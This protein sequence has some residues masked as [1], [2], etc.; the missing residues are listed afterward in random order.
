MN[1]RD[2]LKTMALLGMGL[3]AAAASASQ[4]APAIALPPP[5]TEGGVPL[6]QAIARRRSVREFSPRKLPAQ[7]LSNLLW[8]AFGVNRRDSGMRTAPSAHN[9]QEIELYLAMEEGS[10]PTS[11]SAMR[12]SRSSR[13]ICAGARVSSRSLPRRR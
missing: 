1:R 10:T 12:C 7:V 8:A 4:T 9:T 13:S 6:M 3:P 2:I 5:Q 11:T